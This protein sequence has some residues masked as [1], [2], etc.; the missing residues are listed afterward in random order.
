MGVSIGVPLL[1][2]DLYWSPFGGTPVLGHLHV[3]LK[4]FKHHR[5]LYFWGESPFW[6]HF[7]LVEILSNR[8]II[9]PSSVDFH[10]QSIYGRCFFFNYLLPRTGEEDDGTM[11]RRTMRCEKSPQPINA[12]HDCTVYYKINVI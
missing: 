11:T 7:V 5:S 8:Y 1:L 2:D 6:E 12:Y 4:G 3:K 10:F 9:S